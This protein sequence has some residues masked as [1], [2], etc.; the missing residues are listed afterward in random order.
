MRLKLLF[1]L[2][3]LFVFSQIDNG[4]KPI[5][6]KLDGDKTIKLPEEEK[7]DEKKSLFPTVNPKLNLDVKPKTTTVIS[8][9]FIDTSPKGKGMMDYNETYANPHDHVLD[10]L[11]NADKPIR[12]AYKSDQYFG[13]FESESKNLRIVCRDHEYPDGDRVSVLINDVEVIP[14]ILLE[15]ASKTFYIA[16]MPGF[17]KI[18]FLALNQGESGPNTAAFSVYHE[19]GNL[20]ISNQW[21]LTTGVKAKLVVVKGE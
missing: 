9:Y 14:N 19:N 17:N 6:I 18:E 8:R 15:G 5:S 13:R 7:K 10:K 3:P 12:E 16:L 11:N 2:F 1:I 4:F 20:M 21:N